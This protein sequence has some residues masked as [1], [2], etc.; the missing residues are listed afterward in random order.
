[1]ETNR[2]LIQVNQLPTL[3]EEITE[4]GEA[5]LKA[6]DSGEVKASDIL[7]RFKGISKVEEY[8]KG[9]L[10]KMVVNELS[11]YPE[12]V[13]ILNGAEFKVAEFGIK[14]SYEECGDTVWVKLKEEAEA[15]TKALKQREDFL[16]GIKG[17]ETIVD[18]NTAEIIT[19][20]PP[21]KSSTTSVQ[22][23]IK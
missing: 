11:A 21:V 19:V 6:L 14:Y 18:P 2:Q 16:K 15:A 4:F 12:K 13:V 20:Y 8:I 22:I 9:K 10:S 5:I 3:K 7:L 23:T 17:S 1:M